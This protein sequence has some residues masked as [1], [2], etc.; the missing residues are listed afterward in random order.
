MGGSRKS[1]L[2]EEDSRE[3]GRE[4]FVVGSGQESS[5]HWFMGSQRLWRVES[6][7]AARTA[8]NAI[9]GESVARPA[10]YSPMV[11]ALGPPGASVVS[12]A[13]GIIDSTGR[14]FSAN[15]DIALWLLTTSPIIVGG[16]VVRALVREFPAGLQPT[17]FGSQGGDALATTH[18]PAVHGSCLSSRTH[19]RAAPHTRLPLR[20]NAGTPRA[21]SF[22]ALRASANR[23]RPRVRSRSAT[24]SHG[25]LGATDR[26]RTSRNRVN[27]LA[28]LL[29]LSSSS[30]RRYRLLLRSTGR[31]CASI[32]C[33]Y[34]P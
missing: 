25:Y 13:A 18:V 6:S 11:S 32:S 16:G 15:P 28:S 27:L 23:W 34:M 20:R 33:W 24:R 30:G 31:T 1:L 12:Y 3:M 8:L 17:E 7:T 4:L 19:P 21:H 2:W 29:S 9:R 22:P 14:V 5:A 10:V 26:S